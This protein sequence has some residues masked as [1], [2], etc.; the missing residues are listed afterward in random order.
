ML[1][2]QP[3]VLSPQTPIYVQSDGYTDKDLMRGNNTF[4]S[5]NK[6]EWFNAI[7]RPSAA[8]DHV[9]NFP[10]ATRL[11]WASEPDIP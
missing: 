11:R 2:Q 7:N 6:T 4:H 10:V 9:V 8:I 3:R 5:L 1:S